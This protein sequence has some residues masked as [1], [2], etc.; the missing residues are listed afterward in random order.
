[1][2]TL[3]SALKL[4][5]RT[6]KLSPTDLAKEIGVSKSFIHLLLNGERQFGLQ[7]LRGIARA[8]PELEPE[9]M[10]YLRNGHENDA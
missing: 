10:Q 7:A 2:N 3:V 5:A 1:M 6:R 9:I 4:C 8:F